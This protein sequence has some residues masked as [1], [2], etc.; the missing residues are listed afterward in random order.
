MP[1]QKPSRSKPPT[2]SQMVRAT[3]SCSINCSTSTARQHI[4]SRLILRIKGSLMLR[5]Y[6]LF[7]RCQLTCWVVFSQLQK[8]VV[9]SCCEGSFFPKC[10]WSS[11]ERPLRITLEPSLLSNQPFAVFKG[12]VG[13][14]DPREPATHS[15]TNVRLPPLPKAQGY[16]NRWQQNVTTGSGPNPSYTF[17]AN[18]RIRERIL[19]DLLQSCCRRIDTLAIML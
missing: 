17:D 19:A 9:L 5:A 8:E 10:L 6:P 15:R 4:C 13:I 14:T 3:W 7:L 12:W 16:G 18:N 2:K 11:T 1:A